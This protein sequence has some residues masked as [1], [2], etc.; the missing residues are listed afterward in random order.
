MLYVLEGIEYKINATVNPL[1]REGVEEIKAS[2]R[3]NLENPPSLIHLAKQVGMSVAK[4]K[5]IFPNIAGTTI[6]GYLWKQRM[7]YAIY[8]LNE[9][10]MNVKEVAYSVGYKSMSHFS[11]TLGR[12]FGKTPSNF[13]NCITLRR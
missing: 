7:E 8:L 10:Q 5:R 3:N 12:Y 13:R 11:K 2:L 9:G 4:L 6:Y 1:D